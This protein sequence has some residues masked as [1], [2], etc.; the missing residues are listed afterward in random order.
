MCPNVSNPSNQRTQSIVINWRHVQAISIPPMKWHPFTR[1]ECLLFQGEGSRLRMLE[2]TTC[3]FESTSLEW[4]YKYTVN[5][6]F[7]GQCNTVSMFFFCTSLLISQF[8]IYP[9]AVFF[10]DTPT[11]IHRNLSWFTRFTRHHPSKNCPATRCVLAVPPHYSPRVPATSGCHR[12]PQDP[13]PGLA[14]CWATG[15]RENAWILLSESHLLSGCLWFSMVFI[16]SNPSQ[17]NA[18]H[19]MRGI[20]TNHPKCMVEQS[21]VEIFWG[22]L[23]W[24]GRTLGSAD[25]GASKSWRMHRAPRNIHASSPSFS[26]RFTFSFLFLPAWSSAGLS[27]LPNLQFPKCRPKSWLQLLEKVSKNLGIAELLIPKTKV[28][29]NNASGV[30][31]VAAK[32][33]L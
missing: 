19:W 8:L 20:S 16:C 28:E 13:S 14:C 27:P 12:S 32:L 3:L 22:G 23:Q 6:L 15:G 10:K 5:Q 4:Q 26:S 31:D 24:R 11:K 17:K 2:D 1:H 29:S 33:W 25:P 30:G 7:N 9:K 18:L 21:T